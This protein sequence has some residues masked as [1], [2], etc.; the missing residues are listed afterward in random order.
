MNTVVQVKDKKFALYI[1]EDKIKV[2][3]KELATK[4]DED[5]RKKNPL[6]KS[7]PPCSNTDLDTSLSDSE[8]C[9]VSQSILS[10]FCNSPYLDRLRHKTLDISLLPETFKTETTH[11]RLYFRCIVNR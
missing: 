7:V 10:M 9:T 6:F 4:I 1:H 3:V 2:R 8:S 5:L 11:L